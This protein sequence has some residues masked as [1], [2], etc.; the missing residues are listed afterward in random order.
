MYT[1]TPDEKASMVMIYTRDTFVR[2]E[3]VTRQT[4]RINSWL[5]TQ[6]MPEYIH[7][8]RPQVLIFGSNAIKSL[9][10]AEIYVPT[11]TVIGFHLVPPLTDDLD[12]EADE[13]NRAMQPV[14]VLVGSFHFKGKMRISSQTGIGPS[15]ESSR[16]QWMSIYDVEVSNP[17]LPQMPVLTVPLILL[18]PKQVSFSLE[19]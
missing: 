4:V 16:L 17:Y 15:L 10:Y 9:S 3:V 19:Q 5:R 2:G 6:G 7:L 18:N 13:K 12:Y 11:A 1:L 8:L 14:T